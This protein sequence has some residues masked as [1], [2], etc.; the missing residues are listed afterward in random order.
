MMNQEY[1][2]DGTK[3]TRLTVKSTQKTKSAMF[4]ERSTPGNTIK[5]TYGNYK[6]D[7]ESNYTYREMYDNLGRVVLIEKRSFIYK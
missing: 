4:G 1:G 6:Y 7:K 2:Y 5:L 3:C